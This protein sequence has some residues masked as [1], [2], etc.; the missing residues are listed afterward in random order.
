MELSVWGFPVFKYRFENPDKIL[1]EI[2][3][4]ANDETLDEMSEDWNAKCKSTAATRN[5][6]TMPYVHEELEK[7]LEKFSKDVNIPKEK[8]NFN[9]CSNVQCTSTHCVDYWINVYKKGDHQDVHYHMNPEDEKT[10]LF[11]FTYFAK[12]DPEKDAKFY[13]H[14]PSPAPRMYEEFSGSRPEFKHRLRLE[15]SQGE[16]IF[17]PPFLLHSVDEQTSDN[18]R[19]TLAGNIYR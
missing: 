1:E 17:F 13:F 4:N 11:S 3:K 19:I 12:Y 2:V 10:P 16:L 5:A 18:T 8:M 14:N 7:C 6:M 15:I 9:G